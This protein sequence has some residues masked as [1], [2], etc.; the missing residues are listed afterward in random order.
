M[1]PTRELAL[2]LLK[3]LREKGVEVEVVLESPCG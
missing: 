2:E 1:T 3:R